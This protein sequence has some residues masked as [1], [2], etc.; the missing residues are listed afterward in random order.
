MV[1]H[2]T[3]GTRT[4]TTLTTSF[5]HCRFDFVHRHFKQTPNFLLLG[6]FPEGKNPTG[7]IARTTVYLTCSKAT[8]F[9][10]FCRT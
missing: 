4:L 6:K 3:T 7:L 10:A 5:L 1:S 2:Q 9:P 8:M